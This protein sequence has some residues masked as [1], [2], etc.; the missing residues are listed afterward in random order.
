MPSEQVDA[1]MSFAFGLMMLAFGRGWIPA[2][3]GVEANQ[4][5]ICSYGRF[6]QFGGA[7]LVMIGLDLYFA[8]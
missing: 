3:S 8:D 4:K 1:L 2:R 6:L 5:F 7:V